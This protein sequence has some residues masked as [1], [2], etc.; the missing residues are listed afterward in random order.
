MIQSPP[1][2]SLDS[3]GEKPMRD[4]MVTLGWGDLLEFLVAETFRRRRLNLLCHFLSI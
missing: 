1:P 3:L 4:E 2:P